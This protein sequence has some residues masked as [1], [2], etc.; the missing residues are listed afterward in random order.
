MRNLTKLFPLLFFTASIFLVSGNPAN[1]E[2]SVGKG[3]ALLNASKIE[4][5]IIER[6]A[7]Y[8]AAENVT[9]AMKF[10]TAAVRG[11]EEFVAQD[12]R[13]RVFPFFQGYTG[14]HNAK[15][16]GTS[17]FPDGSRGTSHYIYILTGTGEKKPLIMS[18]RVENGHSVIVDIAVNQCVPGRHPSCDDNED[19]ED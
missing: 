11:R 10:L 8:A 7:E 18:F 19:D 13:T 17:V 6:F 2:M 5:R 12:F 14:L 16:L 1:A 15:A 3:M 9:E 4:G